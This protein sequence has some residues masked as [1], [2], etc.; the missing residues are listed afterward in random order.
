MTYRT[1]L[2]SPGQLATLGMLVLLAGLLGCG[3]EP[4]RPHFGLAYEIVIDGTPGGPDRPPRLLGDRLLATLAYAGGCADHAFSLGY[5]MRR[6]TAH[7]WIVHEAGEEPCDEP[8]LDDLHLQ[9]PLAVRGSPVIAMHHPEGRIP[10]VLR[11]DR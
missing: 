10:Y 3:Q 7:V 9:L 11:W 2:F 1:S 5:A 6:D 4:V 8:M